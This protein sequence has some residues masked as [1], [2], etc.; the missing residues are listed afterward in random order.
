M[1]RSAATGTDSIVAGNLVAIVGTAS[2]KT[3]LE[4]AAAWRELGL[5]A[6]LMTAREALAR[7]HVG[8]VAVGRLDVLPTLDGVE[9]GLFDLFRLERAR[10]RVLNRASAL[11]DVHDKLRTARVLTRAGLPHPRT[12]Q[13]R[14][15]LAEV[16]L[17]PPVVVKPRFGS[18]GRDVFR[19]E[20]RADL[21]AC[22]RA[23][24]D[25]PWFRRHGA[26]VQEL[27]PPPGHDLRLVVAGG[28][29]VGA[30]ERRPGPDEWRTNV[31]LGAERQP[32]RPDALA[33]SLACR[34]AAAVEADLVG[35][36]LL[37]LFSG[38]YAVIELNGAVDFDH[39]YACEGDVYA[40]AASALGL[41]SLARRGK[42]RAAH[43][44]AVG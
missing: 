23:V 10:A 37:P 42:P 44:Y 35:V 25:R 30:I 33:V 8:D 6:R 12:V 38:G 11:V 4:L 16:G 13:T 24:A 21:V 3:N 9:P 39:R 5:D 29:V 34:A 31:S 41:G 14:S 20:S 28:T 17:E 36:D 15:P 43:P 18:W 2:N 26:L 7:L 32:V 22:L 19:C 1:P 40:R 27:L